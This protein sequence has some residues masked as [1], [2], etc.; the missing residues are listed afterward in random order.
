MS[1][2]FRALFTLKALKTDDA[3]RAIGRGFADPSALLKH[4][5]AYVLGQMKLEAALP[6]LTAVLENTTEDSM[7]RHEAAEAMGAIGKADVIPVLEKYLNDPEDAVRETCELAVDLLKWEQEKKAAE[8]KRSESAYSSV[9]PAPPLPIDE[10][11]DVPKLREIL[12][13]ASLPLFK[14][15]RAM[16]SLRNVGTE[17]AVLALADGFGDKSALFRH[18][19]AYVFGQLQHPASV[20]SLAKVLQNASE[21]GM[22]RHEAAEALGSIATPECLPLLKEFAKDSD[23]VV[24]ESCE[25]GVDMWEYENSGDLQYANGLSHHH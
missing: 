13:D 18:E 5:V 19:I 2:R 25:V 3:V 16:F 11:N 12:L 10:A 7:V 14:R 24:R 6:I 9:D 22:V 4:E 20:P 1:E 15:Y 21:E 23:D 17:E 8:G